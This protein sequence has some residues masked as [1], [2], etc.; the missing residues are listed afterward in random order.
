MVFGLI[1]LVQATTIVLFGNFDS[2]FLNDFDIEICTSG[3]SIVGSFASVSD[4][5]INVFN[6]ENVDKI[7]EIV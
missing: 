4:T 3:S 5:A 6:L 2:W 1:Y 7:L